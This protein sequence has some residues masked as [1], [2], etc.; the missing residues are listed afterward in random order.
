MAR[1]RSRVGWFIF[2]F[3]CWPLAYLL[4][5]ITG[6]SARLR[7]IEIRQSQEKDQRVAALEGRV[8]RLEQS[9]YR[10]EAW[11]ESNAAF[12]KTV[13]KPEAKE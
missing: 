1:D 4:L 13:E 11:R 8:A 9:I 2:G 5:L 7:M 10:L 12:R 3:L 6:K